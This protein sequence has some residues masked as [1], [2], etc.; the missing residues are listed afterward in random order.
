[1]ELFLV[2]ENIHGLETNDKLTKIQKQDFHD[3]YQEAMQQHEIDQKYKIIQY[4]FFS[5]PIIIVI[6]STIF[7]C[8]KFKN[9]NTYV[10]QKNQ[11]FVTST[12]ASLP[13]IGALRGHQ[14]P[15]I[16]T[17]SLEQKSQYNAEHCNLLYS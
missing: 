14:Q 15:L 8:Y 2:N 5:M 12:L 1:M 9:M 11:A 17:N 13:R 10:C 3:Q 16:N 6:V 4:Q 7:L